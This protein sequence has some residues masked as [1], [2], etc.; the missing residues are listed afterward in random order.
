MRW[1]EVKD[2]AGS[3]LGE[4]PV[5]SLKC[6][7]VMGPNASQELEKTTVLL[8]RLDKYAFDPEGSCL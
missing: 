5:S 3:K 8:P 2:A 7:Y 1:K 4:T 6:C